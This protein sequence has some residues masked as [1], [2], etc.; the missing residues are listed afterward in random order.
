L[1]IITFI[2]LFTIIINQIMQYLATYHLTSEWSP[3]PQI[4]LKTCNLKRMKKI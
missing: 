2:L 3:A 1:I 4:Y